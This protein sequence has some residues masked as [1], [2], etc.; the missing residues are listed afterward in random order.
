MFQKY[1][2]SD[3]G[4]S[5]NEARKLY[6]TSM[7]NLEDSKKWI[8][9]EPESVLFGGMVQAAYKFV[10][11]GFQ[12]H[13]HR[14][15]IKHRNAGG[16]I[17]VLDKVAWDKMD[18]KVD[19]EAAGFPKGTADEFMFVKHPFIKL[20]RSKR[21]G[22]KKRFAWHLQ[23]PMPA[24]TG[25]CKEKP[26]NAVRACDA[27]ARTMNT[28]YD[29]AGVVLEFGDK[30]T[31]RK[32]VQLAV[33]ANDLQSRIMWKGLSHRRRARMKKAR[34]RLFEKARDR[35]RNFQYNQIKYLMETSSVI[36]LPA[37]ETKDMLN[38]NTSILSK[39]TRKQLVNWS[40]YQFRTK[41]LHKVRFYA[42]A[43]VIGDCDEPWT[44]LTCCG[45][46]NLRPSFRGKE[47]V[48]VAPQC[49]MHCDR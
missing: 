21:S 27:G 36:L 44:T 15:K 20:V 33:Q 14:V 4:E 28:F 7:E 40:H 17:A 25:V 2:D 35:R 43:T 23:I 19:W 12:G 31:E 47:F 34:R 39:L 49:G 10:D 26:P 22:K 38:K 6:N 3:L 30:R 1:V 41:M 48:C 42:H 45:C 11:A 18:L 13:N 46:G 24:C 9:D 32:R 5:I 16:Q 8:K 29:P 37:F